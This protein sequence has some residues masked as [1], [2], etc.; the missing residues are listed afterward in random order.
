MNLSFRRVFIDFGFKTAA[1]LMK[2]IKYIITLEE[3]IK[4]M[5]AQIPLEFLK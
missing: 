3:K 1:S 5:E 2:I 4:K